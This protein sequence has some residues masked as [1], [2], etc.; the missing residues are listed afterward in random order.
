MGIRYLNQYMNSN[1]KKGIQRININ[2]LANKKIAIDAS[3]YMYNFKVKGDLIEYM[4][5]MI[6]IFRAYNII[7]VFIFD[8]K[9]PPE[10]KMLL[11]ERKAKKQEALDSINILTENLKNLNENSKEYNMIQNQI[12]NLKKRTIHINYQDICSVKKL[13]KLSGITYYDSDGEADALCAKLVIKNIVWG[14]M[15]DDMDLFIYGCPRVIRH[16]NLFT[17][18]A[19]LYNTR[20]ILKE[21][22]VPMIEFKEICVVSGTDYNCDTQNDLYTTMKYY[23]QYIN[24]KK[25][26]NFYEWLCNNTNYI[27]DYYKLCVSYLMFDTSNMNIDKYKNIKIFNGPIHKY[28]LMGF[29]KEHNFIFVD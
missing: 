17:N 21:L 9:P 11:N 29:L 18:T 13:L 10:K 22:N 20:E 26:T 7:P 25:G 8:G 15:S 16:F 27:D 24:N 14:C 23:R 5:K 1:C 19:L 12:N 3:I 28:E 4:Y 6:F 2:L